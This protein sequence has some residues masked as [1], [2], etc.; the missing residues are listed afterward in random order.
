MKMPFSK[1]TNILFDV[2][3]KIC[4]SVA[5]L[6]ETGK[7]TDEMLLSMTDKQLED[8]C[9]E[10]IEVIV[11]PRLT[12]RKFDYIRTEKYRRTSDKK[13][14]DSQGTESTGEIYSGI[15]RAF[16]ILEKRLKEKEEY[17]SA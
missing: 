17:A 1:E 4:K 7:M 8:M 15:N 14:A 2:P 11:T 10:K 5:I 9:Y 12:W 13:K 6:H 3:Y 16:I